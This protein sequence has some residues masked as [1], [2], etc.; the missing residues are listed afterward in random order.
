L[1]KVY[2]DYMSSETR[3]F[4]KKAFAAAGAELLGMIPV[5]D[6]EGR[7]AIPEV[8]IRYE[9]FGAKA[10]EVIEKSLNLN[11]IIEIAE[12]F[13]ANCLDYK[14]FVKKF[15]KELTTDFKSNIKT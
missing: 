1:N 13:A 14:A 11:K 2:L 9:E 6:V 10:F 3:V 12:P 15:I 5:S 8:E 7:G 4:V